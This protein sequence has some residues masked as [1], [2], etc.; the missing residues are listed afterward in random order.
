MEEK[1]RKSFEVLERYVG[2]LADDE[3]E[4]TV[5]EERKK[6]RVRNFDI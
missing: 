3:L 5:K 4:R 2:K 6:F 1:K